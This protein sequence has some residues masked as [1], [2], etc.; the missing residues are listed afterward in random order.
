MPHVPL[1]S[2]ADK[3]RVDDGFAVGVVVTRRVA[4]DLRALNASR[5]WRKTQ[6]VHGDQDPALAWLQAIANVRKCATDDNAH[7]VGK[8]TIPQLVFDRLIDQPL[9]ATPRTITPGR[10]Q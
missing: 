8:I 6:I 10:R 9:A 7:G 3:S 1:L 2:H 5:T 4:R